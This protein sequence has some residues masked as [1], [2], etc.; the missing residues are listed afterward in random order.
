MFDERSLPAD[1]TAV[2]DAHAAGALVFD[3]ERDFETLAPAALDDL[4]VRVD[5]V[6]PHEYE[7]AWLPDDAPELLRRLASAELTVGMPGDG[8]VAWTTQTDP[9]VLLVKPRV[10]G[11]PEDFVDFLVARAL[12]EAG[13]D[14]PEQFLGLFREQYREFDDALALDPNGT[15]QVAAAL[16]DAY[17]GLHTRETFADWEGEHDPLHAAWADAGD[18]LE[19]RLSDLA[20]AVAAGRTSFG[21]AAELACSGVKHGVDLP[22]PFDALDT[23]AYADHGAAYAVA[24]AE[25]L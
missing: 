13:S 19:P 25:K 15:Y 5:G 7:T 2:R 6:T 4:L 14:L 11:S 17:R 20:S 21:D 1:V 10:E 9:P 16:C 18:R 12:V 24:W 22:A 3:C 23:L 8:S